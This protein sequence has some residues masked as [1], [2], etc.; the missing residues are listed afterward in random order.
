MIYF[1]ALYII[2]TM[3]CNYCFIYNY[4]MCSVKLCVWSIRLLYDYI[5]VLRGLIL[6]PMVLALYPTWITR[7][8]NKP[9]PEMSRES[10][11]RWRKQ[12]R[13]SID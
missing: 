1:Q 4:D 2:I 13:T 10:E 11:K 6:Y 8:T 3:L 9:E 5:N 7:I 12:R